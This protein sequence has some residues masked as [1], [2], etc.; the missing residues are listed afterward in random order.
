M[1]F[2]RKDRLKS[3]FILLPSMIAIFI[4]VYLFILWSV[5]VSFSAWEGVIPDFT[6]VGL[7]NYIEVFS[8]ERFRIDLWNTFYFT[9]FF[10]IITISGGLLLALI[11]DA[12]IKGEAVFR[13]IFMFPMALSFVVT[14]IV[15][16][17]IFNPKVGLNVLFQFIGFKDATWGW[18]TDPTSFFHFHVALIPVFI[19][20]SW[21]L[22]GYTMAMYLASLRGIPEDIKEA[23]RVDGASPFQT[24]WYILL[25]MLRPVTLS[26]II[27]LG[28]I[29]LKIFDLV[30]SMTGSG[31]GFATDIPGI[32]MFEATFRGNLYAHGAVISTVMLIMV[33]MVIVP[34]LYTT[35]K[36]EE[37]Q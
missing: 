32:Y 34:Y 35:F 31:P 8:T 15:W 5:R 14:G 27:V 23:A 19:A 33:T 7:R 29:S 9:L 26:A 17:W 36:K 13:T 22:T 3:F 11:L 10:I 12:K 21:Q 16:R 18:Y 6:F 24:F 30:Y 4:F 20:A 25:P 2:S 28:H 1:V 37:G